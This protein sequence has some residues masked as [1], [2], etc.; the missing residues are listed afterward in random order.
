MSPSAPAGAV[1]IS[2][3]HHHH[4]VLGNRY[5]CVW[6]VEVPPRQRTLL[7]EHDNSY[8]YIVLGD[9][10]ITNAVTGKA[11]AKLQLPDTTVNYSPGPLAHVV[12]NDADTPF[13]NITIEL[14]QPQGAVDKH[15]PSLDAALASPEAA[16]EA[17]TSGV[18]LFETNEIRAYAVA[19]PGGKSWEA[20]ADHESLVVQPEK[21]VNASG[22]RE[23]DAPM[24]P[25]GMVRWDGAEEHLAVH[26]DSRQPEKLLVLEFKDRK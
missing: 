26:N 1:P 2:G 8:A 22:P 16:Q 20:P 3:E 14:L 17:A 23:K 25:A 15:Y 5:V 24:F 4:L 6:E 21:I 19:V 18:T 12:T 9:A 10:D 7:H 11:P 13:R